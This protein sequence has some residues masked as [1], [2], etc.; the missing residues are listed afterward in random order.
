MGAMLAIMKCVLFVHLVLSQIF[1]VFSFSVEDEVKT[2][3]A[4][5]ETLLQRRQDDYIQLE[6]SLKKT[7]EKNGEV[8]NLKN[9]IRE[10][11]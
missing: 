3:K 10:L 1:V 8:E 5:V 9:E 7:F 4:Q 2:L 11:R 6:E